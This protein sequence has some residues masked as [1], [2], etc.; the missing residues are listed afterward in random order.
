MLILVVVSGTKLDSLLI[1]FS[2]HCFP[3]SVSSITFPLGDFF[4]GNKLYISR[5][6]GCQTAW[7]VH[8]M[9]FDEENAS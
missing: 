4:D 5:L 8:N 7:K 1:Q 6:K 2:P 9:T 3:T